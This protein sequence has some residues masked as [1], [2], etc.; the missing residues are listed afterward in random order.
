M[1]KVAELVGLIDIA[2]AKAIETAARASGTTDA[3]M[4]ED[5]TAAMQQLEQLKQQAVSGQLPPSRGGG[6]GITRALGEWAPDDLFAA[7]KTVEDYFRQH[8]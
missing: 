7:G 2:I 5:A 6:L 3:W 4:S 1:D 8:W